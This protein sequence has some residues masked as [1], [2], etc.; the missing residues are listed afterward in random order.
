[1]PTTTKNRHP[2]DEL[3][4]IKAQKAELDEREKALKAQ[5]IEMAGPR[6]AVGG[7]EFIAMVSLQSRKSLNRKALED[8]FGKAAV[9][10]CDRE[11]EPFF[12]VKTQP[13]A[14]EAA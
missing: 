11:G 3:A 1:M 8:R 14:V 10:A 13:R 12:V 5:I 6:D 7:D 4:D 2:V 9:A